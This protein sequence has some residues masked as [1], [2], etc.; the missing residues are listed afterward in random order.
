[1]YSLWRLV[2][3]SWIVHILSSKAFSWLELLWYRSSIFCW[4]AVFQNR[5]YRVQSRD[6]CFFWMKCPSSSAGKIVIVAWTQP[7]NC[8][9]KSS[10]KYQSSA[11]EK[12]EKFMI[13]EIHFKYVSWYSP[14]YLTKLNSLWIPYTKF[15][16]IDFY[17]KLMLDL[18]HNKNA[19]K[20]IVQN[21]WLQINV[22]KTNQK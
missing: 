11:Y 20:Y 22:I 7:Q 6:I 2:W 8:K 19:I 16:R 15:G 18:Y 9:S 14:N 13:L 10:S 17:W 3:N 21:K 12:W 5:W 4:Y 1:M